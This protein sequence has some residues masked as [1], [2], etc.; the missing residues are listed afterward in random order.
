MCRTTNDEEIKK[1]VNSIGIPIIVKPAQSSGSR[2]VFLIDREEQI[3]EAIKHVR[4]VLRA[5]ENE[6]IVE[7]YVE[8]PEVSVETLSFNGSHRIIAITDKFTTGSPHWVEM[9]HGQ[10]SILPRHVQDRIV[11]TTKEGL[12]ALG[13]MDTAAHVEIKVENDFPKIIEIGARLGGDFITTELTP[14]STGVNMVRAAISLA[15]G[16]IPEAEISDNKGAVIQYFDFSPGFLRK[17]KGIEE[18]S[19]V[20]GVVSVVMNLREG[21]EIRPVRS[22]GDRSGHVIATGDTREAAQEAAYFAIGKIAADVG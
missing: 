8:G 18:A 2:G 21:D 15:L 13:I 12:D 3:E 20:M 22:S 5:E 11:D 19:K 4:S 16:E 6:V 17:I 7:K 9:G 1:A 10:P 14:R